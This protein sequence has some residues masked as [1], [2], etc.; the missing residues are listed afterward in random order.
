METVFFFSEDVDYC[1]PSEAEIR[2]WLE[3]VALD[4]NQT[5]DS[6][7]YIFCSDEYL[8][9]INREFLNHDYYTDIITFD[10]SNDQALIQADIFISIDRVKENALNNN[11]DFNLELKRVLVH[12]LLHL[13]GYNDKKSEEQ[14]AMRQKE[15]SCLS[16][17]LK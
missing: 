17:F 7:N 2:K 6:L 11:E 15:D 14:R 3:L 1:L 5:L 13:I 8:L 9:N 12:G 16:L 4:E 10:N